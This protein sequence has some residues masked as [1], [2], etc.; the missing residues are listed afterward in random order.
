MVFHLDG[1]FLA[2]YGTRVFITVLTIVP[3]GYDNKP[4]EFTP[5]ATYLKYILILSLQSMLTFAK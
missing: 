3:H 5:N 1:Q 4:A 2:S